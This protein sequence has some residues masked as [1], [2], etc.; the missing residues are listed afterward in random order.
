MADR[1]ITYT[2]YRKD[3][4]M[5]TEISSKGTLSQAYSGKKALHF[6]RMTQLQY[7]IIKHHLLLEQT[8]A[9]SLY[10]YFNVDSDYFNY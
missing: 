9:G 3:H 2:I 6:Q 7:P 1:H 5:W 10:D 4:K 8:N